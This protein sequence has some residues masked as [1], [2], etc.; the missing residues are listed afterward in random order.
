MSRRVRSP[1]Q[2]QAA[3]PTNGGG[4]LSVFLLTPLAVLIFGTLLMVISTTLPPVEGHS[5]VTPTGRLAPLFTPEVQYWEADILRW[6]ETY[7]LDAN[8]IATVMQIES[9]GH[10]G[11]LSSAGAIGLFQVMPYHFAEGEDAYEVESNARRG[12]GYLRRMLEQTHGDVRLA[13]AAYNGGASRI[14]QEE[15]LWPAETQR[16]VYWGVGIYE[17]AR[18]GKAQSARLEEWLQR[19]GWS[20]CAAA[21][22]ALSR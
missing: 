16:Y 4:C 19:G 15:W 12:L 3:A 1:L 2:D 14:N 5:T 8:L 17:D 6:S 13:L 9:C 18:Q 21:R 10:P 11:A 7:Q 20:L 22:R